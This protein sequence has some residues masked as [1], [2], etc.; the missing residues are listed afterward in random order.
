MADLVALARGGL[1]HLRELQR[2]AIAS[3]LKK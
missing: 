2:S 3:H 1:T